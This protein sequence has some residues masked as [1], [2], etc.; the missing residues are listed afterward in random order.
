VAIL[1][2]VLLA[3]LLVSR[4]CGS[5]GDVSKERAVEIAVK[6][7]DFEPECKQV[8]FVR[9]GFQG[10]GYWAVS[11]WTLD[12]RG[13]FEHLSVVLVDSQTGAVADVTEQPSVS[14]TQAQCADP[15]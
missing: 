12:D 11:L 2:A 6:A 9:R 3:A 10:R 13:D 15:V 14:G 4:G 8:R 1:L 7:L 5:A